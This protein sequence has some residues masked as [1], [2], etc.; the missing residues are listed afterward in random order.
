[1]NHPARFARKGLGLLHEFDQRARKM[2]SDG[3]SAE[4]AHGIENLLNEYFALATSLIE[5][6]VELSEAEYYEKGER[7]MERGG[8]LSMLLMLGLMTFYE[9]SFGGQLSWVVR[10][11]LLVEGSIVGAALFFLIGAPHNLNWFEHR[12]PILRHLYQTPER[13]LKYL[14]RLAAAYLD[15][16]ARIRIYEEWQS[17]SASADG[18]LTQG[19]TDPLHQKEKDEWQALE[20]RH[21]PPEG[22][23]PLDGIGGSEPIKGSK[24]SRRAVATMLKNLIAENATTSTSEVPSKNGEAS[25][26]ETSAPLHPPSELPSE[27]ESVG[28]APEPQAA[29]FDQIP[30]RKRFTRHERLKRI[31]KFWGLTEEE[32]LLHQ[33]IFARREADHADESPTAAEQPAT[34]E[35]G[36]QIIKIL[37]VHDNELLRDELRKMLGDRYTMLSAVGGFMGVKKARIEKPD[38][39]L[40]DANL[41]GKDGYAVCA[42]LKQD[43]KLDLHAIPVIILAKTLNRQ[44]VQKAAAANAAGIIRIEINK[45]KEL[46]INCEDLISHIEAAL[47]GTDNH[48]EQLSESLPEVSDDSEGNASRV[49]GQNP[50]VVIVSQDSVLEQ[51]FPTILKDR[52]F[53]VHVIKEIEQSIHIVTAKHP[54]VVILDD[55]FPKISSHVLGKHV[56]ISLP[57]AR[58][59]LLFSNLTN[60]RVK[61]IKLDGIIRKAQTP[62]ELTRMF[63]QLLETMPETTAFANSKQ[64]ETETV[65][66][67]PGLESKAA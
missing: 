44:N 29:S 59:I 32:K 36:E 62:A 34:S 5:S 61:E 58:V 22:S 56:N 67:E 55:D 25:G 18:M 4:T 48:L 11:L 43:P 42:D 27:L 7:A 30:K 10:A 19:Q 49:E 60:H 3:G 63:E 28:G 46:V 39:I 6:R 64:A 66:T 37:H 47:A 20:P 2:T 35:Q 14:D 1:M 15:A 12:N 8:G 16:S 53:A 41:R 38:L 26:M 45:N 50:L 21:K 52:G 33:R 31:A 13:L 17:Q 57:Q 9:T 54:D 40:V 51:A 24:N 65:A 23:H